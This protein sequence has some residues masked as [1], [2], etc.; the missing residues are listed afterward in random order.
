MF[1]LSF[2]LPIKVKNLLKYNFDV[3]KSI[4]VNFNFKFK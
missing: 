3:Y 1:K 4:C 2:K